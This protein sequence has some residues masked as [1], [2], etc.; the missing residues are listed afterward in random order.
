MD[1]DD[2]CRRGQFAV[3]ADNSGARRHQATYKISK[4]GSITAEDSLLIGPKYFGR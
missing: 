1:L 3:P 4:A 2:R